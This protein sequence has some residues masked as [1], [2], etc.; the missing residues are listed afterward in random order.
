MA[1]LDPVG[2]N[3]RDE[4]F[5]F[6]RHLRCRKDIGV[7]RE[8]ARESVAMIDIQNAA[9]DATLLRTELRLCETPDSRTC[10]DTLWLYAHQVF[11]SVQGQIPDGFIKPHLV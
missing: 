6:D 1:C 9:L 4:P 3:V 5:G 10:D 8:Q 7:G 2:G 11:E